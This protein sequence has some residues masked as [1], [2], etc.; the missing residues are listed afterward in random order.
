M[1]KEENKIKLTDEE[2]H[3]LYD[4]M[5]M[6]EAGDIKIN[7]WQESYNSIFEKLE[8]FCIPELKDKK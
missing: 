1:K 3:D 6:I 2:C 5:Y 8:E 7:N 4:M